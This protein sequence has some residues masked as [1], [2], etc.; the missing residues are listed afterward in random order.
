MSAVS[1]IRRSTSTTGSSL[2]RGKSKFYMSGIEL[3]EIRDSKYLGQSPEPTRGGLYTGVRRVRA[4]GGAGEWSTCCVFYSL[5]FL[6][7]TVVVSFISR[8]TSTTY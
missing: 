8:R 6:A 3:E 4:S 1:N 7:R 2:N 5:Q